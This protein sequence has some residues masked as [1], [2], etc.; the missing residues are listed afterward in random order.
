[1]PRTVNVI[2]GYSA[3]GCFNQA[4]HPEPGELLVN[5]DVVS[6]GPLPLLR[7]IEKW[8]RVRK[9]YWD[10]IGPEEVRQSFNPDLLAN[11]PA[12]LEADSIVLWLGIGTAEQ[13][14][15][16]WMVQ[17]LKLVGSSAKIQVI[18]YTH[19]GRKGTEVW[20]T[21]L[22]NPD[23][24]LQHP[25]AEP[26]PAQAISE[27]E[28]LWERIT[29]PDPTD[30]LAVLAEQS[31]HL[32]YI[33][34]SLRPLLLRYPDYQTGLGR[35]EFELLRHTKRLG[36]RVT[37]VIGEVLGL[38][39]DVDLIGDGVLFARLRNLASS[40]LPHPLVTLS[41]DPYDMRN[42]QVALTD[43]GESVLAGRA[44]AVELNGIN[45]WIL[46]VHLDSRQGPVWYHKD[47]TLVPR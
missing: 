21:G 9:A 25:P 38:N 29:S 4:F 45:D 19:L 47:G 7:P 17:L 39:F 35:W 6:C 41:G 28:H 27:L 30:L 34:P 10:S 37:R 46:G 32:P 14:L 5:D 1:M 20:G 43:T 23:Q 2:Q 15:L 8:T 40:D 33:R 22:L 31:T 26:L 42:C 13:L 24:F 3:A 11:T 12:L 16:A 44:N 36:P 18:Q